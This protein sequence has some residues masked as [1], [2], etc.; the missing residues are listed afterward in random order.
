MKRPSGFGLAG[1]VLVVLAA[2]LVGSSLLTGPSPYGFAYVLA[3]LLTLTALP[4]LVAGAIS[5][6]RARSRNH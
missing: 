6:R 3:A 2:V 1:T 5:T 4:L